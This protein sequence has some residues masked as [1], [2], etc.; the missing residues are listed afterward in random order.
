MISKELTPLEWAKKACDTLMS[1][2]EAKDLPPHRF[3]YHQG[4]FLLGV[5]KYLTLDERTDY[6]NYIKEWV[7]AYVTED[8]RIKLLNFEQLDDIQPGILLFNLYEKTKEE[9]YKKALYNLVP[10]LKTWK[11]NE[12]GGF[13]HKDVTPNQMWLDGLFMGGPI[14]V[15]FGATFD[16]PEY[17]DLV[18]FQAKLMTTQTKDGQTGLLYH[19]WDPTKEAYWADKETGL[20]SEFWGRAIGWYPLALVEI[21]DYL[22]KDHKNRPFILKTLQDLINALVNY[23]DS[24][25]LWYQVIDKGH[26]KDNWLETSCSALFVAA[27]AKAVRMGYVHSSLLNNAQN[28]YDGI[29][30]RLKFDEKDQ[31]IIDNICVGTPIGDYQFYVNRPTSQNDLHGSGAFIIMCVEMSQLS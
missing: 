2:Y 6:F 10:L 12:A 21:L 17:F 3:H 11:T 8:G 1:T 4:V 22:P 9:K 5:E 19:G 14:G 16:E 27:I 26:L 24:T 15:K 31:L 13:W 7:D 25:G 29:I 30:N 23:Q 28:G 18:T 20:S